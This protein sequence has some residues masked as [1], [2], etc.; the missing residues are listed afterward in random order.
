M[1][2]AA[3]VRDHAAASFAPEGVSVGEMVGSLLRRSLRS[4][5]QRI[6]QINRMTEDGALSA[7]RSLE[8]IVKEAQSYAKDARSTLEG[9]AGSADQRGIAEVIAQQNQVLESFL[10][11]IGA[12]VERQAEVARAAVKSSSQ[13]ANLGNEI[14]AVAF[15]SRL[16]SL[17]ASIEAGRMGA[18]GKA[19]GVI[20]AEMTK[21][22]QQVESTS[23]AVNELVSTLSAT[24]PSVSEA[25]HEMRGAS[26]AFTAEISSS[27]SQVDQRVRDLGLSVQHTLH[28]G[29]RCIAK[30]L[31][32]SQDALSSLQFQDPAAQGMVAVARDF[33]NASRSIHDLVCSSELGDAAL[34]LAQPPPE[35]GEGP[36]AMHAEEIQHVAVVADAP[37][38]PSAG[39]VLLF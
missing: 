29:D 34:R 1:V 38:M 21:L 17:N 14:S 37:N 36:T 25:A 16:L 19:F 31:S 30:I 18:Q 27:I 23:K 39:E 20:A 26:E 11:K 10:V 8:S 2:Q 3:L 12:Q 7:G 22:S 4:A 15:Q 9:I 33:N 13:I 35:S 5:V 6:G 32:H 28:A 24:L